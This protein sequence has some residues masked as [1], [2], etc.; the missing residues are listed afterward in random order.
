MRNIAPKPERDQEIVERIDAGESPASLARFFGIHRERVRQI[1]KK[2]TGINPK[3]SEGNKRK[4]LLGFMRAEAK[5]QE[6]L[7]KMLKCANCGIEVGER[8]DH[9][10]FK[11]YCKDCVKLSREGNRRLSVK[12]TCDGCGIEYSPFSS[13]Y[14]NNRHAFT[15]HYHNMSC[16]NKFRP[17]INDNPEWLANLRAALKNKVVVYTPEWRKN[18]SIAQKRR[19]ARER[20]LQVTAT[21]LLQSLQSGDSMERKV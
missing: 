5:R 14:Y 20:E 19:F 17:K 13:S 9:H 3:A 21:R 8:R 2:K 18:M 6:T 16:Y 4:L 1:Y 7:S 10:H 11:M 15:K 12:L